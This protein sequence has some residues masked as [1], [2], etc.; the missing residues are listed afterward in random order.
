M[1]L[2]E[3]VVLEKPT[4]SEREEGKLE[5]VVSGPELVVAPDTQS[6]VLSVILGGKNLAVD[7]SRAQVLVRPFVTPTPAGSVSESGRPSC[8]YDWPSGT[9]VPYHPSTISTSIAG[10]TSCR[11]NSIYTFSEFQEST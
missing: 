3:V 9:V 8:P 2:Y 10:I 4:E 1:P 11:D 6:A 7:L 5:R